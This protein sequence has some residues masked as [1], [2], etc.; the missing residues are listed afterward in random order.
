MTRY[1]KV[2]DGAAL[3]GA[4]YRENPERFAADYLH[5]KLRR[6]QKLLLVMMC[7]S[8]TFVFIACRG[9]GKT[10]L[11]AIYCVIRCILFP[12]T[13]ICVASG[14]RGQGL[15]IL[16]K[17]MLE[18]KPQSPELRAEIDEKQTK[19]NGTNAQ[20]VFFNTSII[21][22]VTASDS[23]RGHR[24]HVLVLDEFRLISKDTVDT[25]LSKFLTSKR[26]PRY[27][28]LT[29]AERAKERA[30]EKLLTMYLSS[31]YFT[32]SWA[33]TK[34]IDTFKAMMDP[35]RHQFVCGFPYQLAIEEGLLEVERVEDAMLESD[36]SE[37]KWSIKCIS[38]LLKPIEPGCLPGVPERVLTGKL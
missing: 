6:F 26:M 25:V 22:V 16:E 20:I 35:E 30:K 4:F 36:F 27:E 17:I 31:A 23:A 24:C 14:T 8:T 3:W 9:I 18:L 28:D 29:D 34:C 11:S 19:I 12:G 32:S 7:W 37:V 5:L 21:Q 2:M 1:E 10:F 15:L 13:K 38:V 33:Y